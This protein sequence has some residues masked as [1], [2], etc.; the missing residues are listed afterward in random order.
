MVDAGSVGIGIGVSIGTLIVLGG[1][2]YIFKNGVSFSNGPLLAIF[3]GMCFAIASFAP[4]G[5]LMSGFISDVIYGHFQQSVISFAAVISIIVSKLAGRFFE[6]GLD[7]SPVNTSTSLS[8]SGWCTIPGLEPLESPFLPMSILTTWIISIY[9][10]IFSA[11]SSGSVWTPIGFAAILVIQLIGFWIGGCTPSYYP[12]RGSMFIN[13]AITAAIGSAIGAGMYGLIKNHYP[14]FAP[15]QAI[16]STTGGKFGSNA[17]LG[18]SP[19]SATCSAEQGD[20][21]T[22]VAELYKNGQLVTEKIA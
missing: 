13:I 22:F 21:N 2:G 18:N 3:S 14:A 19:A 1:L 4:F 15:Y 12:I 6:G 8:E 20:E 7:L 10:I 16:N 11:T 17:P 5:L 9:Y